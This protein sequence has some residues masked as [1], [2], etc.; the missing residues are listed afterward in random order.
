MDQLR[1][2]ALVGTD[3]KP[4][5][6]SVL[7]EAVK[8]LLVVTEPEAQFLQATTL[9]NFYRLAG[10]YPPA[11]KG[12]VD[13]TPIEED[14]P[15]A[16]AELLELYPKFEMVDHQLRDTV[17]ALWLKVLI[18][19]NS[20]VSPDILV[21]LIRDGRTASQA[22]KGKILSVIGNKGAW[23]LRNDPDASYPVLPSGTESWTEGTTQER[24]NI[25]ANLHD[26]RPSEAIALLEQTWSTESVVTKKVF[27]ELL[28][29]DFGS[30]DVP[31]A[32]RCYREEF[33]YQPK[34]KKTERECRK[35][36]AALLLSSAQTTLYN[37]ATGRLDQYFVRT[38]KG[39]LGFVTGK[40]PVAFLL[41]ENED[42]F[43][44]A[45]QVDE[46][47]GFEGKGFDIAYFSS[48]QLYWL[49]LLI[50]ALPM[51]YWAKHFDAD[52][53]RSV[54]YWLTADGFKTTIGGESVSIFRHALVENAIRHRDR[55][56]AWVLVNRLELRGLA[57]LLSV[58]EPKNFETLVIK[59]K[60]WDD[61]EWLSNGPF[62]Q[63][64]SWSL[65]FSEKIIEQAY[66]S[67]MQNKSSS[68]LG[69]VIAKYAH[70]DS[71]D[72]LYRFNEKARDSSLYNVWN[73]GIFQVAYAAMEIRNKINAIKSK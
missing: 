51:P 1:E 5:D 63:D 35:L 23:I 2:T 60:Y 22:T 47:F 46:L 71:I 18:D 36:L 49:S 44:N 14:K 68:Q 29:Q 41:P 59:N 69:K 66:E 67:A 52:F 7:P 58:L 28:R 70:A 25:F 30:A 8:Q 72:A 3:K 37:E 9:L 56:L 64:H 54:E 39:L 50:E 15:I 17:L 21:R 65:A 61:V 33:N 42:D 12:T 57:P 45:R 53:G 20:I 32:E 4:L 73:T 16:T 19:R 55:Q 40:E 26:A 38:K 27:L 48:P 13:E 43:W 10:T 31:F 62:D 34:E 24:K 6:T 11:Y